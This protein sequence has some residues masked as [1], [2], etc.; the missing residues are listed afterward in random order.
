MNITFLSNEIL[1]YW[2]FLGYYIDNYVTFPSLLG[3]TASCNDWWWNVPMCPDRSN[4]SRWLMDM[5]WSLPLFHPPPVPGTAKRQALCRCPQGCPNL[6]RLAGAKP[7]PL[8]CGRPV[9][10]F[11]TVSGTVRCKW[12][13][14][15][16]VQGISDL[17]ATGRSAGFWW[18]KTRRIPTGAPGRRVKCLAFL[19]VEY[20]MLWFGMRTFS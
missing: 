8:L 4:R 7:S 2:W 17:E 5:W 6:K 15:R 18:A 3:L 13:V 9:E 19:V 12:W 11:E 20:L 14:F 16:K 1:L 10:L